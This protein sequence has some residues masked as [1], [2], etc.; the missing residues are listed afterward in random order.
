M[1]KG[2]WP[3]WA[4]GLGAW[5]RLDT[6]GANE[7]AT[8]AGLTIAANSFEVGYSTLGIRAASMIPIGDGMVLIP[9]ASATW[10]HAFDSVT[11]LRRRLPLVLLFERL[12]VGGHVRGR[13]TPPASRQVDVLGGFRLA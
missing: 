12:A 1:A 11:P 13:K 6:N 5:V 10:Q 9:R 8:T 7:R 2:G 4:Q 3:L